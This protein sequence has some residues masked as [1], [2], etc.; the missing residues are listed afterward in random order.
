MRSSKLYILWSKWKVSH[1]CTFVWIVKKKVLVLCTLVQFAVDKQYKLFVLFSFQGSIWYL[2]QLRGSNWYLQQLQG[3]I[4]Y[5]QQL[6]GSNW[7]LQQLRGSIWYLQQLRGSVWYIQQFGGSIWYLQLLRG[8]ICYLQKGYVP[9]TYFWT[10]VHFCDIPFTYFWTN[11]H[12]CDM[13]VSLH[14]MEILTQKF[15]TKVLKLIL[16]NGVNFRRIG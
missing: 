1:K 2:Q 8:S 12:F 14:P 7:Y 15:L 13:P 6:R 3:S 11:V 16:T 5:L 4:W 10:N 9:F